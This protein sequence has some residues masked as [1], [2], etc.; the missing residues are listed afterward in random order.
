MRAVASYHALPAS[1]CM[2]AY[3]GARMDADS[4]LPTNNEQDTSLLPG[5]DSS[6]YDLLRLCLV[7]IG[8]WLLVLAAALFFGGARRWCVRVLLGGGGWLRQR[9]E[10]ITYR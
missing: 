1:Y 6:Q 10:R 9:K 5:L 3:A 8:G 4:A 7:V 2:V